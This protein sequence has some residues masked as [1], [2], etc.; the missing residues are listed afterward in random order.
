M[1]GHRIR[2]VVV[3]LACARV[4]R[5]VCGETTVDQFLTR[6]T[7]RHSPEVNRAQSLVVIEASVVFDCVAFHRDA[8]VAAFHR[9]P[10]IGSVQWKCCRVVARIQTN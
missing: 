8:V 9:Y 6:V 1:I 10:T 4:V 2:D 5:R 7:V 3:R